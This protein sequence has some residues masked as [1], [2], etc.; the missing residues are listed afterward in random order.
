ME[1][2]TATEPRG[3]TEAAL[4][5]EFLLKLVD[6]SIARAQWTRNQNRFAAS[7]L[8]IA[9]LVGS[10]LVTIFLGVTVSQSTSV[11]LKQAAFVIGALVTLA[12]ALEPFFNFRSLWVEFDEALATFYQL[13]NDLAFFMTGASAASITSEELNIFRERH[14]EI[15]TR[16]SKK[17]VQFRR[18]VPLDDSGRRERESIK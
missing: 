7:L 8:R 11:N 16:V 12:N 3:S 9:T 4:K 13:R 2:D 15:W 17:W 5:A 14:A 1:N 18:N 10:T 6:R